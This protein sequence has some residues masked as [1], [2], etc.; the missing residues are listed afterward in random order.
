LSRAGAGRL[1]AV[2][3]AAADAFRLG[4]GGADAPARSAAGLHCSTFL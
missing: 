4:R 1:Q 2:S 3:G